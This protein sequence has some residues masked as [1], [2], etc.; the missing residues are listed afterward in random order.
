MIGSI[1]ALL[2]NKNGIKLIGDSPYTTTIKGNLAFM[3]SGIEVGGFTIKYGEGGS[4]DFTN[5]HYADL[6]LMGDAGITAIDSEVIIKNC[7]I[8]PNPD[9]FTTN[10]G[11]GIQMW[12]MYQGADKTPTIENN[13]ILHADVGISLFSQ[14]FGGAISG[15]IKNN[16]LVSNDVG[17]LLRMHKENPIIQDN[18]ITDSSDSGVHIT[19]EDGALLDTRIADI[20]GNV[21]YGNTHKVWCDATQEELTPLPNQTTEQQ[22]NL[23][24][25]PLLDSDYSPRNLACENKGCI[26]Q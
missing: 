2:Q 20:L 7:I 19:Y 1:A 4:I 8:K 3:E 18:I 14:A 12:N 5:P 10:F 17:I 22:G 23:Y 24:E 6:K 15:T 26:L 16:T 9:I 25:N 13:L 11:K 21:F